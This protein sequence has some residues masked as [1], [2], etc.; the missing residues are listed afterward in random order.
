MNLQ[1]YVP[2]CCIYILAE[3][4]IE[5]NKANTTEEKPVPAKAAPAS[6]S[7]EEHHSP[8][9]R[10]DRGKLEAIIARAPN[11]TKSTP[12]KL[13]AFLK[14]N[15][16]QLCT[17]EK[18][19]LVYRWLGLNIEY[20]V[21]G[22]DSGGPVAR[23]AE[24]AFK[25]GKA[26]CSGY[27]GLCQVIAENMELEIVCVPG[28][29]KGVGYDPEADFDSDNHDWNAFKIDGKWYL[30]DSTWGAGSK[31]NGKFHKSYSPYY[32]GTDPKNLIRSHFPRDPKWQFLDNP[33]SK[34]QFLKMLMY[35]GHFYDCGLISS[36]PDVAVLEGTEL[37]NFKIRYN[38]SIRM[39][40]K[41]QVEYQTAGRYNEL[42]NTWFIQKLDA[43]FLGKVALNK[44]GKYR[45]TFLARLEKDETYYSVFTHIINCSRD[46][47]THK[48]FPMIFKDFN[49]TGAVLH[50]PLMGPLK[51]GSTVKFKVEVRGAVNVKV[52]MKDQ[53]ELHKDGDVFSGDV[54]IDSEIVEVYYKYPDMSSLSSL[55]GYTTITLALWH[56]E[57]IN[58]VSFPM[59]FCWDII[60]CMQ[61]KL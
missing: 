57:K 5:K 54:K 30:V 24:E 50:E 45:V 23:T 8:I 55:L 15:S 34:E 56:T 38:P 39:C 19:W 9:G 59:R 52:I 32:F 48:E 28:F 42:K 21:K 11:R 25:T 16:A 37:A 49:T 26:V 43:Y 20:D 2:L 7:P 14:A 1:Q 36:E 18:A 10:I 33:V 35:N 31:L 13:A 6:E 22:L 51:I 46:A 53:V 61:W 58:N 17:E 41:A 47:A 12:Q 29:A 60:Y 40:M 27:S 3:P 4:N 44:K